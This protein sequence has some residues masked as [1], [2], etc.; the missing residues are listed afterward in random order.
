MYSDSELRQTTRCSVLTCL[1]LSGTIVN[2]LK[3]P[4]R[5]DRPIHRTVREWGNEIWHDSNCVIVVEG[6]PIVDMKLYDKLID[7]LRRN[8]AKHGT[9][10]DFAVPLTTVQTMPQSTNPAIQNTETKTNGHA[11]VEYSKAEEAATAVEQLNG[12]KLDANHTFVVTLFDDFRRR[13]PALFE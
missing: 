6:C 3:M 4:C 5:D 11:I 7:M 13:K 1:S 12:W 9:I 2:T 8:C 10:V